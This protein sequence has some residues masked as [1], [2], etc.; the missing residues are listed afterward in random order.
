VR[1]FSSVDEVDAYDGI[2]SCASLLHVA[3]QDMPATIGLLWRAL[4]RAGC[5]YLS[6][7]LGSG[8]RTH[9]GRRFTDAN[10]ATLRGWFAA[11][12]E[13]TLFE[14]WI[15]GDKRPDS[16]DRWINTL[17]SRSPA[18]VSVLRCHLTPSDELSASA[19]WL[20]GKPLVPPPHHSALLC[21]GRKLSRRF[22]PSPRSTDGNHRLK[23][24]RRA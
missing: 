8:E 13:V 7:K 11:L 23:A 1:S 17:V 22:R 6:F 15:T 12:P 21:R 9:G 18:I 4:R 19:P 10:D 16:V 24:R 3:E 5:L 14:T 2:W 20:P